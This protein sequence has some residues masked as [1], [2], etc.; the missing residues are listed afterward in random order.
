MGQL[1]AR[2]PGTPVCVGGLEDVVVGAVLGEN[3]RVA[4]AVLLNANDILENIAER[5]AKSRALVWRQVQR[6]RG[7]DG[8]FEFS[9]G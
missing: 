7:L 1:R 4:V 5:A 9:E 8:E 2:E 3:A 6:L